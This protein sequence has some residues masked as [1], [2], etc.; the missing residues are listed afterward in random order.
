MVFSTAEQTEY[1]EPFA[2]SELVSA[3]SSLKR[4]SEGPD[5]LHNGMLRRL[6]AAALEVLL[7]T[8]DSL[9]EKG[10]FPVACRESTVIPILKHGKSGLDPKHYR[11]ISLTSALC[12]VM[13]KMVNVHLSWFLEHHGVFYKCA[14]WF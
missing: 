14:V 4:V 5:S 13:K 1:N 9:W 6:P 8:L 10:T 12:K 2:M 11:P 3:T 7:P